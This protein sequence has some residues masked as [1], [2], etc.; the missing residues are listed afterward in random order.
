MAESFVENVFAINF[1]INDN[2]K[3]VVADNI[4]SELCP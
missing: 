4:I 1:Q 2:C 3:C